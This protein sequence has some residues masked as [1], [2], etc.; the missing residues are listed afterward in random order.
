MFELCPRAI[1]G[2]LPLDDA[3]LLA[4][5]GF[6]AASPRQ[7]PTGPNP[8]AIRGSGASMIVI[9]ARPP[10]RA[11][12][13]SVWFGGPNN[14]ALRASIRA[15]AEAAGYR[16]QESDPIAGGGFMHIFALAG[17]PPRSLAIIEGDAGGQFGAG[18]A[19]TVFM[20]VQPS[21]PAPAARGLTV[22]AEHADA[23]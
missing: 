11:G 18:E 6:T 13:C 23:D 22:L 14:K 16:H 7:T 8:R 10:E 1:D 17:A 2:S 9:S 4:S 3:A 19:T 20:M 15:R 21:G 12:T 5:I